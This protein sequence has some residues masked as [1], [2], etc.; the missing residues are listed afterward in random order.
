M[1]MHCPWPMCQ[2][3]MKQWELLAA[4]I[5]THVH[6]CK[7]TLL[8]TSTA[9][10]GCNQKAAQ[11][12]SGWLHPL[13]PKHTAA[14]RL[15]STKCK[16]SMSLPTLPASEGKGSMQ[17]CAGTQHFDYQCANHNFIAFHSKLMSQLLYL[18]MKTCQSI[19]CLSVG[20]VQ[21]TCALHMLAAHD[22]KH[23]VRS[24]RSGWVGKQC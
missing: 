13:Q 10:K 20:K 1:S 11:H 8:G 18:T 22:S 14:Q 3:A 9:P 19:H 2:Q 16:L 7:P 15:P 4:H 21:Q 24:S 17:T 6:T 23:P 5:C 12:H